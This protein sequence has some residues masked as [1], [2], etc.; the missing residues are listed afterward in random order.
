MAKVMD[1]TGFKRPE[2]PPPP[3]AGATVDKK[4]KAKSR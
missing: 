2:T 1:K 4:E 3:A